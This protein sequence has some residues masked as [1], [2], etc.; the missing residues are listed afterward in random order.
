M[1]APKQPDYM[2]VL[3]WDEDVKVGDRAKVCWTHGGLYY[4]A[5]GRIVKLNQKSARVAID[6]PQKRFSAGG[7]EWPA[8]AEIIAPRPINVRV[9]AWHNGIQPPAQPRPMIAD[10]ATGN[11]RPATGQEVARIASGLNPR[12]G[13]PLKEYDLD[14]EDEGVPIRNH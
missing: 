7:G 14:R 4:R 3:K 12:T 11:A 5:E 9:W 13:K 2:E 10:R 6:A 8:G 1:F